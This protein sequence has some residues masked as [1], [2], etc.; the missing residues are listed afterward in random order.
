[1]STSNLVGMRAFSQPKNSAAFIMEM[2]TDATWVLIPELTGRDDPYQNSR[3][4]GM[5]CNMKLPAA[6]H[7]PAFFIC[8][9]AVQR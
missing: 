5:L 4:L 7:P 9:G 8:I 1:M 2:R 6:L 3:A